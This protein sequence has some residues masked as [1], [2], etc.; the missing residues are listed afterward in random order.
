MNSGWGTELGAVFRKE[1]LSEQRSKTGFLTALLSS[2]LTVAA[3]SFGTFTT[4]LNGTLA[5]GLFW[6]AL[7]FAATVAVP[8]TFL[9]EEESGTADILRLYA[10][11]HAV[12]WGKA[13]FTSVQ[14]CLTS[15]VLAVLFI[16]LMNLKVT[17]APMLLLSLSGGAV[18]LAGTVTFC[19]ALVAQGSNRSTLV[20]VISL[21][22][23]IP[24]IL[25]GISAC[26]VAL[27]DGPVAKGWSSAGGLWL[28]G[29]AVYSLAPNLFAAVWRQE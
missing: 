25:L 1:W 26:R 9:S 23:L 28:Y 4:Q 7:S 27:G 2:A 21:P 19:A 15:A 14:M 16:G 29:V 22:M 5:S 20:G 8:R 18:A 13:M 6:V 3:I 11:P 17:S 24:L 12:F 10:R